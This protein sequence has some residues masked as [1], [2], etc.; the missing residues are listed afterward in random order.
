MNRIFKNSGMAVVTGMI[1]AGLNG[2]A[3]AGGGSRVYKPFA[4]ISFGTGEK[5]G[6]GYFY[7]EAAQCKLVVTVANEPNWE[8]SQDFTA[9]RH[10]EVIPDSS[11]AR[12][13]LS[14][15]EIVEFSCLSGGNA[16]AVRET[17]RVVDEIAK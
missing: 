5:H 2:G 3:F 9:S 13:N 8:G 11:A 12:Y 14:E 10:E 4:A 1:L 15:G 16:M 17:H 6:V 7:P